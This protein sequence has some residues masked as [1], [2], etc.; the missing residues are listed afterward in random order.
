[1]EEV[2]KKECLPYKLK[3]MCTHMRYF[4]L[5]PLYTKHSY[6]KQSTG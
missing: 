6:T 3:C 1:M 4:P 5:V 2:Q